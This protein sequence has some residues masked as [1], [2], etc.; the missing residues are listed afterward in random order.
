[1]NPGP[2]SAN[3]SSFWSDAKSSTAERYSLLGHLPSASSLGPDEPRHGHEHHGMLR[4][5][6]WSEGLLNEHQTDA[7]PLPQFP[8]DSTESFRSLQRSESYSGGSLARQHHMPSQDLLPT[9]ESMMLSS[10]PD[11]DDEKPSSMKN[12]KDLYK[13]EICQNWLRTKNCSYGSK[14]HYAHGFADMRARMR[15]ETFKTQPCADPARKGCQMCMYSGRCNY[16]H[17]GE[18]IRRMGPRQGSQ[19]F[20]QEYYEA[21]KRDFPTNDFPFGIYV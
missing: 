17:P 4:F 14:C 1:M 19:Y 7:A 13:T 3:P 10:L 12:K 6:S 11:E 8:G 9:S 20:D 2:F 21:I 15:I 5:H 18:A 16:A